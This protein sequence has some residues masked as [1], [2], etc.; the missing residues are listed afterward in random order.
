MKHY[1]ADSV[2]LLSWVM[3]WVH[4][5]GT[6][7]PCP[8]FLAAGLAPSHEPK[9]AD[10]V[11]YPVGSTTPGTRSSDR[12]SIQKRWISDLGYSAY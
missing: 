10:G 8:D 7:R 2:V 6:V 5:R 3:G 4:Q 1:L 9:A 11:G 12:V